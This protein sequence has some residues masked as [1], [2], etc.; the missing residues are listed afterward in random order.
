MINVNFLCEHD[1]NIVG[2]EINGH[3]GDDVKGKDIICASVSS[4]AFMV[5]NT[6][7]DVIHAC[8]NIQ[9]SDDGSMYLKI[10][11]SDVKMCRD[12]VN[13]LKIH[14]IQLEQQYPK[15]IVVNYLEV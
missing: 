9:V 6:I 15:N 3:A 10:N 7:T 4:A 13:G 12:I 8:A 1:G 2:F 14:M 11:N 5:A